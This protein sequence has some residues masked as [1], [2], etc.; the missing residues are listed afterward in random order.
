MARQVEGRIKG[1]IDGIVFYQTKE[2]W[3]ARSQGYPRSFA[4]DPAYQLTRCYAAEFGS[5][6]RSGKLLRD[7]L[8]LFLQD[9]KDGSVSTR[10]TRVL[11]R[12]KNL[13][14]VHPM[15]ERSVGGGLA[16][17]GAH[18][19]LQGFRFN[20][21]GPGALS[22]FVS[23]D[24]A[25]GVFH[26]SG[27][28]PELFLPPHCTVTH[29]SVCGCAALVDFEERSWETAVTSPLLLPID[30]LPEVFD[31]PLTAPPSGKGILF[32]VAK[33]S[34]HML[35]NGQLCASGGLMHGSAE[36]VAIG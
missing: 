18:E 9:A 25:N 27:F 20:S 21:Q 34:F 28:L 8:Q 13:D 6:A 26:F 29:I 35:V 4:K 14:G 7:A 33:V 32:Y 23:V 30:E 2:G 16:F 11:A 3:F 10:L 12:V 5:V 15:G 36:L 22:P 1:T 17:E 24:T 19:L 31:L